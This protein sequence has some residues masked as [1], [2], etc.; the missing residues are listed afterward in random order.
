MSQLS[1]LLF[2]LR[3]DDLV[4]LGRSRLPALAPPWTDHNAHDPGITLIELLAWVAEAQLY[5]LGRMRRDERAAYAALLGVS[6]AG[7]RA[8]RGLLWVDRSDAASPATNLRDAVV[9]DSDAV[10]HLADDDTLVFHPAFKTLFAPGRIAALRSRAPGGAVRDHTSA[11]ERGGSVFLPFGDAAGPR[12]VL[13]L[14][15]ET[16]SDGGLF[17]SVAAD[18]SGAHWVIG[19]RVAEGSPRAADLPVAD[20]AGEAGEAGRL[21]VALLT[22]TDRFSLPV[23]EDSS[24][25]MLRTGAL[26]LD[27]SQV[28]DSPTAFSLEFRAPRGLPRAP[29]VLRIEP[30]VLPITQRRSIVGELHVANGQPDLDV[31]LDT[32]GLCFDAG[33]EPVQVEVRDTTTS[34]VWTRCE[35]L[36]DQGPDD[37][38]FEFDETAARLLFGNGHNGRRP[39]AD[40]Q[41]LV[42]YP[43]SDGEDGN[44]ARNRTWRVAGVAGTFGV[45][46][47]PVYGGKGRLD[48][49]DLRREARRHARDDHA[50]V[51][52]ADIEAASK[53]LPLLE[54]IRAWV[55]P[56]RQGV[57]QTGTVTLIAMRSRPGNVEPAQALE[58]PRWLEAVRRQL[59]GRMPLGT[60]L[61]VSAPRYVGFAI[62]AQLQIERGRDPRQ[63]EAKVREALRQRLAL[64]PTEGT[65]KPREPGI[66]VTLRDVAAWIRSVDGVA[67]VLP[68]A[69]VAGTNSVGEIVVPHDGL[70]Q[71]DL[72]QS[73]IRAQ[74][75]A[76]TGSAA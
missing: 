72:D 4:T 33:D 57:P 11:N 12:D 17:P 46:L 74:R 56:L 65:A 30:N 58:T 54:V 63:I 6:A 76:T 71:L 52:A 15:F 38:T 50:L 1:P 13:T 44:V 14:E 49:T 25:T 61:A 7:T 69:L 9:V 55:P 68:L 62:R 67:D 26:V 60:R 28:Q 51:S 73:D 34:T 45:N 39:V 37:N 53:S 29:R 19:I 23:V 42:S 48:G 35:H 22:A 32:P 5:S 43:V 64:V 2:D 3:Y 21:S 36:S 10:V 18:V 31:E 41:V 40:A 70:P 75:A 24:Q 16:R 47:D 59:A 66:P 8:A 27:M 20:S